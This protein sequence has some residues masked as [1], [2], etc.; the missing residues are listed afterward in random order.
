MEAILIKTLQFFASLSLLVLIHEF[1]H[2]ITARM[3]KIRVEQFYIFFNPWF[4]IYKRKIGDTV[5]G[6]GWLPL[7]GYVSLAG[8]IDETTDKEKME[9]LNQR[10]CSVP[11]SHPELMNQVAKKL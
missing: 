6:I 10:S 5:Y 3:F 11:K 4:S 1:G 7:G 2:Y 9:L 8:M